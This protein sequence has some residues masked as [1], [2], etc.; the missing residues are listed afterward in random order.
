MKLTYKVKEVSVEI[1]KRITRLNLSNKNIV[2]L[3]KEIG[4]YT[5]LVYLNLKTNVH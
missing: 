2:S 3:P 5:N 4:E 1:D